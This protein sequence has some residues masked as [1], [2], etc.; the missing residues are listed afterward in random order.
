MCES[1]RES[2]TLLALIVR[3][4]KLHWRHVAIGS[5]SRRLLNQSTHSRVA[6]STASMFLYP[7]NVN[8]NRCPSSVP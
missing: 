1:G 4:F 6:N 7:P 8:V 2:L 3:P 5:R